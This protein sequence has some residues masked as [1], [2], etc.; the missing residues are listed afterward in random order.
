[1]HIYPCQQQKWEKNQSV[2]LEMDKI[3]ISDA[4]VLTSA[5]I[6]TYKAAFHRSRDESAN[7]DNDVDG[8]GGVDARPWETVFFFVFEK[9]E[10]ICHH[11]FSF[12]GLR[13]R[14]W[15]AGSSWESYWGTL[16]RTHLRLRWGSW[17][18]S[19]LS[20]LVVVTVYSGIHT[21]HS[22]TPHFAPKPI[23]PYQLSTSAL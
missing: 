10:V 18:C 13:K 9:E 6:R 23:K 7:N 5:Q 21:L 17:W 19:S 15:S 20:A 22:V 14:E 12:L 4:M 1:M 11:L 2:D 3:K 16:G 8:G